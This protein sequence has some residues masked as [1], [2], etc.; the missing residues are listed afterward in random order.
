MIADEGDLFDLTSGGDLAV[1]AQ[2]LAAVPFYTRAAKK[3]D[4]PR[5]VRDGRVLSANGEKLLA[6]LE[7]AK[8]QPLWRVLV[9]LSI[10]HV[11]PTAARALAGHFG[12]LDAIRA[13]SAD[14]LA[15]GRGRRRGHRRGGAATGSRST[16]TS[17][18][19]TSG[20]RP[21]CGWPTSVDESTPDRRWPA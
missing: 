10:R 11:G 5:R 12:S 1:A 6:N 18:S 16:G 20:P 8:A 13:A 19:S 7:R 2:R 3:S 21:A 17:R 9:A 15:G 4:P 14:E